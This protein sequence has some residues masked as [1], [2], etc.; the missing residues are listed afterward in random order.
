[1]GPRA[2]ARTSICAPEFEPSSQGPPKAFGTP[3]RPLEGSKRPQK[4]PQGLPKAPIDASQ[5]SKGLCG[6][7]CNSPKDLW[8]VQVAANGSKA[9]LLGCWNVPEGLWDAPEGSAT[10]QEAPKATLEASKRPF[11]RRRALQSTF[12]AP[13]G[14]I[15]GSLRNV[16][17]IQRRLR[18]FQ[19]ISALLCGLQKP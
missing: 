16:G 11:G 9:G 13:L 19:R 2:R 5:A 8:C 12:V 4:T 14:C 18:S 10:A 3:E 6:Y 17:R 15:K 7:H 1:M